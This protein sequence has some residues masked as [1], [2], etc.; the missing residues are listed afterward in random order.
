MG[1]GV[2]ESKPG[3]AGHPVCHAK[4]PNRGTNDGDGAGLIEAVGH[5][6]AA[7]DKET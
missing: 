2:I 4:P 7:D 1:H 5:S 6:P 3:A